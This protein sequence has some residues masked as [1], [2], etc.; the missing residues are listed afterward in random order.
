M[1][2]LGGL[3]LDLTTLEGTASA[4]FVVALLFEVVAVFAW[5]EE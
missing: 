1:L 5:S 2:V 4:I 3:L